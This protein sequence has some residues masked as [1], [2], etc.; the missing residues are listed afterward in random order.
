MFSTHKPKGKKGQISNEILSKTQNKTERGKAT[1]QTAFNTLIQGG[2]VHL[3]ALRHEPISLAFLAHV[4]C[5]PPFSILSLSAITRAKGGEQGRRKRG[6]SLVTEGKMVAMLNMDAAVTY[7]ALRS[8]G[9]NDSRFSSGDSLLP[10]LAYVGLS[11]MS[12]AGNSK[13]CNNVTASVTG[14]R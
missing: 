3:H 12:S 4:L 14:A 9:D 1:A 2:D 11:T 13:L 10:G 7:L 8:S 6:A 5:V